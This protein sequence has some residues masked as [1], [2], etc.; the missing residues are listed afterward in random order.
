MS[1][2]VAVSGGD[3]AQRYAELLPQLQALIASE[4]DQIA[5]LANVSAALN[6]CFDWL[7]VGFYLVKGP[8]LVLGPFQGPVACT[9]IGFGKG[10]CGAA[11][12]Q[13]RTLLVQD[14]DSFPGHIACSSLA[15]SEVVVPVFDSQGVVK[16]V[17]DIDSSRLGEYDEVDR[18]ALEQ[19]AAWLTPLFD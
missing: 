1:Y 12:Q 11:W 19:L 8:Q 10:V 9:R 2:Q 15:R 4:Q 7:W 3:K 6:A 14:V 13:G 18:A 5:T 17:L 16:A